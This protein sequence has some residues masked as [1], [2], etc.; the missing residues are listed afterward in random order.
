M[1]MNSLP[2]IG[3]TSLFAAA[4]SA[5][6]AVE[7][8]EVVSSESDLSASGIGVACSA[9]VRSSDGAYVA[10]DLC[11]A[12]GELGR[13]LRIDL[14]TTA[15]TV[16][17]TYPAS[18]R[19]ENLSEHGGAFAFDIL[20]EIDA[21]GAATRG[22]DVHVHDWSLA[23]GRTIAT[24][25]LDG[26][27]G[28]FHKLA[29]VKLTDDGTGVF[30][31]AS[32]EQAGDEEL[33]RRLLVAPAT[34]NDAP[35]AIDLGEG[36]LADA[37]KFST[38]GD[39][40]VAHEVALDASGAVG[41]KLH[42]VESRGAAGP[43]LVGSP[44]AAFA[45][46]MMG[47]G[48]KTGK[49][50]DGS[51]AWGVREG[52]NETNDLVTF[53]PRSGTEKILESSL[54]LRIVTSVGADILYTTRSDLATGSEVTLKKI[55]AAGGTPIV[56]A[57][58]TVPTRDH[59]KVAFDVIAVGSSGSY[60]I[61]KTIPGATVSSWSP[62]ERWL[63]KLDGATPAQKLGGTGSSY[64]ENDTALGDSFLYVEAHANG[65][66]GRRLVDLRDGTVASGGIMQ[67]FAD[68]ILT[69]DGSFVELEYCQGPTFGD[70]WRQIRHVTRSGEVVGPCGR[71]NWS[72]SHLVIAGSPVV[73]FFSEEPAALGNRYPVA[74]VKP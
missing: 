73:V 13:L 31:A 32:A 21:A 5:P 33:A 23:A 2:F 49:A 28:D 3:L 8:D 12:N 70:T 1:R 25:A 68:S 20:H 51:R 65:Q 66:Y 29:V 47:K 16:V 34:G 27:A 53:D 55:A 72:D 15:M 38:S 57:Q 62:F 48:K 74:I 44:R 58:T 9:P 35:K 17:A 71:N 30:Y 22:I 64:S 10:V 63:V 41:E 37:L 69:G 43:R 7:N 52:A 24:A 45:S 46:T 54:A 40:I 42:L 14:A 18:D 6:S 67:G 39:S 59:A 50:W 26:V 4:C 56:L 11:P 36:V 19:L 60:G 61:F